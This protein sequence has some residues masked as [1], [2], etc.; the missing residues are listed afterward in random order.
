M[1]YELWGPWLLP[2]ESIEILPCPGWFLGIRFSI[3]F[4]YFY[5]LKNRTW[6]AKSW[7]RSV[8]IWF[9]LDFVHEPQRSQ[10]VYRLWRWYSTRRDPETRSNWGCWFIQQCFLE[11]YCGL[12]VKEN[13]KIYYHDMKPR[14]MTGS[15]ITVRGWKN[16]I[17]VEK[18]HMGNKK[19]KNLGPGGTRQGTW[20]SKSRMLGLGQ[21]V[22][23]YWENAATIQTASY[24][25][26]Y[27]D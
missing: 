20:G 10:V 11:D 21:T 13:D 1:C 2:T 19:S 8:I 6:E 7:E 16:Q 14:W 18:K 9:H 23:W 26:Y 25:Y 27:Y 22:Q 24:G 17:E 5:Q 4:Y 12:L 15:L 3:F